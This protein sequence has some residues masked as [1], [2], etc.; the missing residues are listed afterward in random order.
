MLCK[1]VGL[2]IQTLAFGTEQLMEE[3]ILYNYQERIEKFL[4]SNSDNLVYRDYVLLDAEVAVTEKVIP[5]EQRLSLEYT[6]VHEKEHWGY[7]WASGWFHF[8]AEVPENFAGK[9]LC[10]RVHLGSEGLF[11]DEKGVPVYGVTG[12]SCFDELYCKERYVIGKDFKAGEKLEFYLQAAAHGL[13]GCALPRPHDLET[14]VHS[15]GSGTRLLKHMR[16]CIFDREMWAMLLDMRILF[17]IVKSYGLKDYRGKR[18]LRI[19]SEAMDIY[20]YDCGN[21]SKV[22]AMLAEKAFSCKAASTAPVAWSIGHGHLDVGWLWPVSA[23]IGKATRTFANQVA[24]MEKYPDYVFGASQAVLY[25]MV[26]ENYPE[27]YEKV[28]KYVDSGRWEVQGG[29][30]VE[31][32]C[33]L[34]SGESLIRQFLHGKN[35]F[36]DEFGIEVNNLWLPDVF[37]Y[38]GNLPQIIRKSG[39]QWFLTQKLSWNNFNKFPHHTFRWQGVD[40]T[41]VLSHFPP[42][43]N[44]NAFGNSELRITAMNSFE[45][46]G[47]VDGFVCLYGIGDGGGGPSEDFVENNLRQRDL[48]GC[49]KVVMG[50]ADE[51]FKQLAVVEDKLPVWKGEL[52]FECHRGTMTSQARVKRGNRKSEQSLTALEFLASAL[53]LSDYPAKELDE[54]WKKVLLNQFHDILPGSSIRKVYDVA[55]A[56]YREIASEVSRLMQNAAGKLFT[57]S[58]NEAVIVN[59]LSVPYKNYLKFPESW[60]DKTPVVNG[61]EL[62][63]QLENGVPVA[64]VE[65]P[66]DSFTTVAMADKKAPV[67]EK[68]ET[69]VLENELIRYTFAPNGQLVSAFDKERNEEVL[70]AP[71]NVLSLYHDIPRANE[72]WDI[73]IYYPDD[74]AKQWQG[75][76]AENNFTG[77]VRS[78][79]NFRYSSDKSTLTQQVVLGEGS[80]RLDFITD[81]DWHENRMMLRVSFPVNIYSD[82][83]AYDIQYAYLK[84]KTNENTIYERAQ[85]EC[86]GQRYADLSDGNGGVALLND[87]KY[88]YRIKDNVLD[89]ALLRSPRFPDAKADIGKHTFTYSF[90]PHSGNLVESD[91]MREAAVL[92]REVMFFDGMSAGKSAPYCRLVEGKNISLEVVKKAEKADCRVIRLVETAGRR[93]RG[94]ICWKDENVKVWE[95]NLIEWENGKSVEIA[96]RIQ[97]IELNP[98]EIKTFM[99]K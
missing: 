75:E 78:V 68:L 17:G 52:Y 13:F 45:E 67:A 26:K 37:G 7:D 32:D 43:N 74:F 21:A 28:R 44:Y 40:G 30:Y 96:D 66:A 5:Y 54:L 84:R 8:T 18:L 65:L 10:L 1:N 3:K 99:V 14:P 70:T 23:S 50:R 72:A 83:A 2:K 82:E 77:K 4:H 34:S 58:A 60:K 92:N 90:L 35:F 27:L 71:A 24:L 85:F 86:C 51:F 97:E 11:F 36:K 91:V 47:L 41:T 9:E 64:A 39:C 16:L 73:E 48:D 15:I 20:N 79:L 31:A 42:E 69:L 62:P 22:R 87:C 6:K 29:M 93:S 33:N 53:Q 81:V 46:T 95:T 19:L 88:G 59:S 89:L 49:P 94:K 55:E 61:V 76:V 38:S 80:R 56:D 12:Y 98:F 25:R 63:V 57:S